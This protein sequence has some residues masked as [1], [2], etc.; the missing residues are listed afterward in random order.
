MKINAYLLDSLDTVLDCDK[1]CRDT[2]EYTKMLRNEAFSFELAVL[3]S[4]TEDDGLW[5]NTMEL[6][7]SVESEL[8]DKIS[9]YTAENVP[10]SRVGYKSSDDWFI[11]KA[12]GIYPDR[13]EKRKNNDFTSPIG[14]ARSVFFTVNEEKSNLDPGKYH[15]AVKVFRRDRHERSEREK[16]T[17]AAEKSFDIEVIDALLPKQSVMATNWIHYDCIARFSGTKPFSERFFETVRKFIRTAVRNGQNTVLLPAFTPPLDTPV[18]GERMTVQL[19]KVTKEDGKYIFD[20]SLLDRFVRMCLECGVEY[21]EHSHLFTQ[22]GAKHAPKIIVHENGFGA[23]MFGWKTDSRS[24]E[25]KTFLTAYITELKKYIAENGLD[26]RFF[27]HISDEPNTSD[28]EC[29]GDVSRFMHGLL[30]DFPSGDALADY[31]LYENGYVKTPIVAT[32]RIGD[33]L[34]RA[35]NIWAYYTGVQSMDNLSNRLIGMPQERGRILGTV[36]YY[37]GIKGFLNWGFNAWHNRLARR[38]IDPRV[39]SDMDGDFVSG[40]SYIVY[41]NGCDVDMSVRLVTFRDSMQDADALALL[42][43]MTNRET[44]L[45]IIRKHIPD[46]GFNCRVKKETLLELRDEVNRRIAEEI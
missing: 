19:V 12:A 24:E 41:P 26:G 10:A 18:G 32:D 36:L 3:V 39:S 8:R 6:R 33:F 25:Y 45:G 44:V 11:S 37:Y 17:L 2:L 40:T 16:I 22:W 7:V 23:K 14:H 30:G 27:F 1:P 38:M 20:F 21:F 15:I 31:E 34:G 28:M 4:Q 9:V 5:N 46:I 35:E 29:Y 13:L 43:S 42:E